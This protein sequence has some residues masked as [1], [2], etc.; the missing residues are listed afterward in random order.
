M[1]DRHGVAVTLE[2]LAKERLGL[3]EGREYQH[4]LIGMST[5][6]LFERIKQFVG[7]ALAELPE[8]VDQGRQSGDFILDQGAF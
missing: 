5:E 4:L 7:L 3:L 2:H 1:E 8:A 6:D